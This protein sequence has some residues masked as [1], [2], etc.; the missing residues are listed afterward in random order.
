MPPPPRATHTATHPARSTDA[1]AQQQQ[2]QLN[3]DQQLVPWWQLKPKQSAPP[4][5]TLMHPPG[6]VARFVGDSSIYA[7]KLRSGRSTRIGGELD[8]PQVCVCVWVCS[9]VRVS[10]CVGLVLAALHVCWG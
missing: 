10:V 2:Q 1:Q 4:R 5:T 3:P 7:T 8:I 6:E 9:C